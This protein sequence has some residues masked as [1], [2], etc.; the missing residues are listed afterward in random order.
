LAANVAGG[1]SVVLS[2]VDSS[3]NETAFQVTRTDAAGVN[4]VFTT[5]A[6]TT[7][8]KTA[9]GG[10][11]TYTDTTAVPLA[12]YTYTVAAVTSA[13]GVVPVVTGAVSAPVT[14][15][16]ALLA[17]TTVSAA[18][19]ATGI[20]VSWTDNANNDIGYQLVRT[21]G[22]VSP[23]TINVSSTAAQKTATAAARTYID[24]TA[25]A[26]VSYA[27]SVATTGG[28]TAAPVYSA[29]VASNAVAA[30]VAAPGAPTAVISTASRVTLSWTDL[31]TNETGFLIERSTDGGATFTTVTTLA[32]TATNTKSTNVAVSY[33]DNLVA[34]VT[35]GSYQYRVTAVNQ[36]GTATNASSAAVVSNLLDFT[37]PAAP[38]ALV[39]AAGATGTVSLSWTDNATNET[40][41][42]VQRAS[43]ATFTTGLTTMAVAGATAGTGAAASYLST[44]LTKGKAYY[45]R[46]AATNLVGASAYSATAT[47]TAP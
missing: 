31:S 22:A 44:G 23:T 18:Q 17:P 33:V 7:T 47:I 13:A 28:T 3:T 1:V 2:W 32:R 20:T 6:R 15:S 41:F 39:A 26:G 25:V 42:S 29:A 34:P 36:T 11:V 5:P 16:L 38:S 19:T 24:T 46:V 45:F 10:A 8:L 12:N 30:L 9:V 14:A 4:V 40:G 35:Q 27:Y 21:G 37:A 43:N